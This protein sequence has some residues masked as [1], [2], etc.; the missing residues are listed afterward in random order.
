MLPEARDL[1]A[2]GLHARHQGVQLT[3]QVLLEARVRALRCLAG[4]L[5]VLTINRSQKISDTLFRLCDRVLVRLYIKFFLIFIFIISSLNIV[6]KMQYQSVTKH[7][8]I[9]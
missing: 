4:Q 2:L 1:L 9:D 7:R 6:R 8:F 5:F 3:L